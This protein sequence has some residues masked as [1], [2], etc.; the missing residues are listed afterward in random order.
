MRASRYLYICVSN[1]CVRRACFSK[2]F[3]SLFTF[4][5]CSSVFLAHF[6]EREL[7]VAFVERA[8]SKFSDVRFLCGLIASLRFCHGPLTF[9]FRSCFLVNHSSPL[10]PFDFIKKGSSFLLIGFFPP[11]EQEGVRQ[12]QSFARNFI[13]LRCL[14]IRCH[15]ILSILRRRTVIL[16]EKPCRNC[17]QR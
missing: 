14:R 1:A 16:G 17:A 2:F 6:F 5:L 11:R 4:F 9:T 7:F 12:F 13:C 3:F 15:E 10:E 8:S